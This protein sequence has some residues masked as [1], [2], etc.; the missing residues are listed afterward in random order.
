MRLPGGEGRIPLHHGSHITVVR[1]DAQGDGCH[2]QEEQIGNRFKLLFSQVG[3]L[4]GRS[5]SHGFILID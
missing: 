4:D 2:V 3:S 5:I 1:R